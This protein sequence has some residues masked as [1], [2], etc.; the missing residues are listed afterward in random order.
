M[1]EDQS[2]R[3]TTQSK[4]V[5]TPKPTKQQRVVRQH[6]VTAGYL[7]RFTQEGE[8]DTLFYVFPP[9]GNPMRKA[10]PN[11]V[12]FERNYHDIHVPG[13]PPD[14]L[15]DFFEKYEGPAS[16][17]FRTLSANPGRPLL[18]GA[19][20]ETLAS[21]LALQAARIPQAKDKYE[22]LV[23]DSR[24]AFMEKMAS[25]P[26]FFATVMA[27]AKR[28]G[29]DIDAA[30]QNSLL[31]GIRSGHIFPQSPKTE[32]SIGILRL[33]HAIADQLDGM[34][35]SLL[36]ANAPEQFICSDHPVALF[37]SLT[38]PEDLLEHQKNLEWPVLQ[39]FQSTIYMPLARNVAVAIH[40][41]EDVPTVLQADQEMVAR[42]N[43]LTVAFAER[44]ICSPT[45][46]FTCLLPNKTLGNS[47][48]SLKFLSHLREATKE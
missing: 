20:R 13:F 44:F 15:E 29:F 10:T 47:T 23:L 26:D 46:D 4:D 21:F 25:S 17:L 30:D 32:I 42:I 31:E 36:Y 6:F 7:A 8:R 18:S 19:E 3:P 22:R 2:T 34:H 14:H 38:I 45:A 27:A 33:A 28:Q 5:A 40:R 39:P 16:S 24:R 37:Y 1:A 12:G 35:Y 43:S 11:S 41:L 9:D 48:D